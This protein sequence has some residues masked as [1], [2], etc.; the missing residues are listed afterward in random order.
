MPTLAAIN[1]RKRQEQLRD[2]VVDKLTEFVD[3][4]ADHISF[5]CLL[6]D[7][8]NSGTTLRRAIASIKI[9]DR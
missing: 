8:E 4:D 1:R 2:L 7:P 5:D 3:N 9:L 6:D